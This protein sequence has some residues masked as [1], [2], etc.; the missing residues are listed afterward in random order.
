MNNILIDPTTCK[1]T[2][3]IDFD[4]ACI[5][6]PAHEFLVSLQDLGGNVMGPY[7]D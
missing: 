2:A 7:G 1:L 3:L 6:H 5:A 4:F